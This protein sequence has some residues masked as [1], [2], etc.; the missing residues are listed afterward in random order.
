MP[1]MPPTANVTETAGLSKVR[2][3]NSLS[4]QEKRPRAVAY[5]LGE[6]AGGAIGP[7]LII[8]ILVTV[9]RMVDVTS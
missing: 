2:K 8:I 9:T 4:L 5:R 3:K 7:D 6:V 1:P